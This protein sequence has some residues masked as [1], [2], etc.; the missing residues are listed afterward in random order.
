MLPRVV[1][2]TPPPPV[3]AWPSSVT[4]SCYFWQYPQ[5]QW[6]RYSP[7]LPRL[8]LLTNP[9]L[10]VITLP[11]SLTKNWYCWQYTHH[12]WELYHPLLPRV[13]FIDNTPPPI[14]TLPGIVLLTTPPLPTYVTKDGIIDN[15]PTTSDNFTLL[16][17]KVLIELIIHPLHVT[18]L[19]SCVTKGW[20]CGQ[21]PHHQWEL[22]PP[23][24]SG[25][26]LL[27]MPT[28]QVR[29]LSYSV[30][31]GCIFANTHN[32]SE[33]FTR[34]CYKGWKWWHYPPTTLNSENF[35]ILCYQ[36]LAL[37]TI[38]PLP[39]S[40]LP[41]YFT[42]GGIVDNTHT[43]CENRTLLCYQ[44]WFCWQYPNHQIELYPP[45]LPRVVMLAIPPLSMRTLP[46]YVTKVGIVKT[47]NTTS[48][49]FNHLCYQ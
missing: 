13:G 35:T 21:Y 16:C 15:N 39:M 27:T 32:T 26:V 4:N 24:L 10:P 9:L 36:R 33:N 6:D 3:I 25:V 5:Y 30:T 18:T 14:R 17:Y 23:L 1:L 29:T 11:S 31:K 22:Y 42:K 12:Q 20:Y 28:P 34:L 38:Q 49:N 47:N 7:L 19:P 44:G 46:F 40:T 45:L 8:E 37:L 43:T 41:S 48:E 2:W